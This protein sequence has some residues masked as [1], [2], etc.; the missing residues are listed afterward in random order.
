MRPLLGIFEVNR[1][2][3][4]GH[5]IPLSPFGFLYGIDIRAPGLKVDVSELL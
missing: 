1:I 4:S 3:D 2:T 5:G